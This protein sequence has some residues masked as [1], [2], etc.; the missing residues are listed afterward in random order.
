MTDDVSGLQDAAFAR[1]RVGD[2]AGA[3]DV[4]AEVRE[5]L[6]A[7]GD[8][9]GAD[10]AAWL[11]GSIEAR[12]GAGPAAAATLEQALA[13]FRTAADE[14]M[15]GRTLARL[16]T[17]AAEAG[18]LGQAD[19]R[20]GEAITAFTT[21]GDDRRRLETLRVRALV[22]ALAGR[23]ADAL[24]TL[25]EGIALAR[26]LGDDQ[27][28]LALRLDRHHLQRLDPT[29]APDEGLDAL[30]AD[31]EA[32]G[33]GTALYPRLDRAA[34]HARAGRNV[35]AVADAEAARADAL[36]SVDPIGY[37]LACLL[38]AEVHEAEGD[39]VSALVVLFT[40]QASLGDLLGPDGRLPALAAIDALEERWGPEAF[41]AALRAY[42]EQLG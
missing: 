30:T 26:R 7:G 33:G 14:T 37:L 13:G 19:D 32:A 11:L 2:L 28:V 40:C 12:L 42:R 20:L 22:R 15:A 8:Q 17:V 9:A 36:A 25:A 1:L 21:A 5:R 3:R 18:E 27:A 24:A 35:L 38:L 16:A 4:V 29:A 23:Q 41:A 39:R 34:E 6:A 10:R 31:A